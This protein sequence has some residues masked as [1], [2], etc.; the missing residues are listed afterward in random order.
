MIDDFEFVLKNIQ[1]DL[2]NHKF[3]KQELLK[4]CINNRLNKCYEIYDKELNLNV[5]SLLNYKDTTVLQ[6][7]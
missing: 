7:L 2:N 3:S 4:N 5:Q 1:K 6:R